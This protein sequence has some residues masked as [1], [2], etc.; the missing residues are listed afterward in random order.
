MS[1][2]YKDK[3]WLNQKYNIENLSSVMMGKICNC[4]PCTITKWMGKLG[5]KARPQGSRKGPLSHNWKG[6]R[7]LSTGGYIVVYAFNHPR[8]YKSNNCVLEHR[9]VMEK[10]LGRYL[11]RWEVV[12]HINGIRTDNR[13]ENLELLPRGEH[14]TFV[15]KVY[16]ENKQL[17]AANFIL[18]MLLNRA[19]G[20]G[21]V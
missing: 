19:M 10:H 5:I 16:I 18:W 14:N 11:E 20:K 21:A 8:K 4:M 6:E 9:L 12:H 13:I 17:R 2:E 3:N 15:Q 7:H 1:E